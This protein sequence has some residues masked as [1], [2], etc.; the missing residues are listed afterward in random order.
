MWKWA[1]KLQETLHLI[2]APKKNTYIKFVNSKDEI[3][4]LSSQEQP[5]EKQIDENIEKSLDQ[6][7]KQQY[8]KLGDQ[9]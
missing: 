2:D 9:L 8:K 4:W 3:K 6:K 5:I 7:K 1:E